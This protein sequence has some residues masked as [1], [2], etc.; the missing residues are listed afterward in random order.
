MKTRLFGLNDQY[1]MTHASLIPKVLL[2]PALF[3]ALHAK[4]SSPARCT[5][6]SPGV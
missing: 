3:V 4:G 2:V 1:F 6:P 5:T